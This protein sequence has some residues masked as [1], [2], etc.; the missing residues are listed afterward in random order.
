MYALKGDLQTLGK[1][2]AGEFFLAYGV[3]KVFSDSFTNMLTMIINTLAC[4]ISPLDTLEKV[5]E[6]KDLNYVNFFL[7]GLTVV[8]CIIW[9]L[10][11]YFNG[12]L[13]LALANA[14]GL[15]CEVFLG[16]ACLYAA[17]TLPRS[18]PFVKM[19]FKFTDLLY[20]RPKELV[21]SRMLVGGRPEHVPEKSKKHE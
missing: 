11:H 8:N 1:L 2:A 13:P 16:F 21:M 6:S 4:V 19:T 18:H 14:L 3:Y 17:G 15:L 5:L 12:A 9:T 10:Y 20:T 7:H